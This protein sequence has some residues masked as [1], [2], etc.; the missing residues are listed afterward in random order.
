MARRQFGLREIVKRAERSDGAAAVLV[1]GAGRGNGGAVG[2]FHSAK[3]MSW[4][5]SEDRSEHSRSESS[6]CLPSPDVVV[7]REIVKRAERSDGA[8]AVLYRRACVRA[9]A[10]IPRGRARGIAFIYGVLRGFL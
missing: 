6:L 4:P 3:A 2:T 5:N 8:A 7:A 1:G 10:R 9:G